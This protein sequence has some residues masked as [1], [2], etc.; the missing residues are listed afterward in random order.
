[1]EKDNYYIIKPVITEHTPLLMNNGKVD[2]NG[3]DFLYRTAKVSNEH[4]TYLQFLIPLEDPDM[5]I[6]YFKLDGYGVFSGRV[7]KVLMKYMPIDSLQLIEA[8]ICEENEVYK[9]FWIANIYQTIQAFD[10]KQSDYKEI[11]K[12]GE[13]VGIKKIVLDKEGL[14]QIPLKERL[15]FEAKEDRTFALYHESIIDIIKSTDPKG[16]NFIL[17]E[18]WKSSLLTKFG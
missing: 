1:M 14:S 18:E 10:E 6:D 17:V 7:R 9:D 8:V 5:S 13:W 4:L 15:V 2:P 11:N 16:M 3:I 12:R